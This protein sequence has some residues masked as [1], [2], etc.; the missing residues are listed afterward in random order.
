MTIEALRALETI[1]A[2]QIPSFQVKFKDE[3][4]LMQAL[5]LLMLPF[6]PTFLTNFTTTIGSA[7]YFP[8]RA[9]YEGQP[10]DSV[11][12]LAHEFVHLHDSQEAGLRFQLSYGA[13]QILAVPLLV[14]FSIVGSAFPL[15]LF[16]GG[17][18]V[19]AAICGKRPVV[20]WSL[21]AVIA[22]AALG[23]AVLKAGWWTTVLVGAFACLGPWPSPGRTHWEVRGYAMN[24]ALYLWVRNALVPEGVMTSYIENFTGPD[25]W[26]MCRDHNKVEDLFAGVIRSTLERKLQR[27]QP[28]STIHTF[29][30]EQG[31]VSAAFRE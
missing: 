29:L 8:S 27:E 19:F 24:V 3:S 11:F 28:Y 18:V 31:R 5:G 16:L 30:V 7:V 26:F 20:F 14:L 17:Y 2:R 6:N 23:L 21:L 12:T 22:L 13:P 4:K 1:I 15:F 10:D 25:Y 9:Q